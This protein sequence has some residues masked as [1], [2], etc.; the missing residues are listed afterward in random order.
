MIRRPPRSTRTDTLL[1]YT[2]LFRS[3]V[4][5]SSRRLHGQP[6]A[7]RRHPRCIAD[8]HRAR[9]PHRHHDQPGGRLDRELPARPDVRIQRFRAAAPGADGGDASLAQR[10]TAVPLETVRQ[11]CTGRVGRYGCLIVDWSSDVCSSYL[12]LLFPALRDAFMANPVLNGVI[13]GALLI[14]IVHVFRTVTM[15]SPEVAWIESFRRDQMSVS[16]DSAPRLLAP[17][18]AMLREHS[19]GRLTLSTTAM[20]SLLDGIAAR[21]DESR[22]ISRYLIGLLVFLGLLGTF[23][24]LIE[25]IKS[26]SE[27]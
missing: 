4:S 3:A 7:Q 20:R 15:I 13:L 9:L 19:G 8:R 21:I 14:G 22:E 25:T 6:R 5:R 18:A 24:G 12:G 23:W 26:R 2:T 11:S 17:M 16:S 27:E 10:R 1:P